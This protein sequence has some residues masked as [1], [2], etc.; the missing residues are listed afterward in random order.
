MGSTSLDIRRS[1][2]TTRRGDIGIDYLPGFFFR[3][4]FQNFR[5]I[6]TRQAPSFASLVLELTVTLG[7]FLAFFD[8]LASI[9]FLLGRGSLAS[10]VRSSTEQLRKSIVLRLTD[11]VSE[12]MSGSVS[13]RS[14]SGEY[15]AEHCLQSAGAEI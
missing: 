8:F 15:V 2:K 14:E 7:C 1:L 9:T 6:A 4:E 3:W 12:R 5:M 13:S 10:N 11:A